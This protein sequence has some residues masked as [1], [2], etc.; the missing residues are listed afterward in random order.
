MA[1]FPPVSAESG[2]TGAD[3]AILRA[4]SVPPVKIICFTIGEVVSS[5]KASRS[6]M[7]TCNASLGTP[8][9]QKALANNQATGAATVAGFSITVFPPA[10]PATMPPMGMAQGKFHGEITSTVPFAVKLTSPNSEK[11]LIVVV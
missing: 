7:I 10:R 11:V 8:A 4:V 3:F 5:F 6:V 9:S 2:V 1:F